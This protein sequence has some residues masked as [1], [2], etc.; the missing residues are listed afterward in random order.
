MQPCWAQCPG[1]QW[2]DLRGS[3]LKHPG[4]GTWPTSAW[5]Q[6][7]DGTTSKWISLF[8]DNVLP[9]ENVWLHWQLPS[10]WHSWSPLLTATIHSQSSTP[11]PP[12]RDLVSIFPQRSSTHV[13]RGGQPGRE[14]TQAGRKQQPYSTGSFHSLRGAGGQSQDCVACLLHLNWKNGNEQVPPN[15]PNPKPQILL[16]AMG[17]RSPPAPGDVTTCLQFLST[18]SALIT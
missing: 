6:H 12:E 8:P 1:I 15:P 18:V 10:Q 17:V 13:L 11:K 5:G 14:A 9:L 4:K 3:G 16:S 2:S 7:V